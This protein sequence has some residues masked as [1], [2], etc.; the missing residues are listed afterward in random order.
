MY[1]TYNTNA[2][3]ARRFLFYLISYKTQ[4][5]ILIP[6]AVYAPICAVP[7]YRLDLG[8]TPERNINRLV[9]STVS[10]SLPPPLSASISFFLL[11]FEHHAGT[12]AI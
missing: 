1:N 4:S 12:R 11:F 10:L 6:T 8:G 2:T 3:I 5:S 7:H 9:R